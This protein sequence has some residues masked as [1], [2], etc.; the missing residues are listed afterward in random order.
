VV[1]RDE[2]VE[3]LKEA[4]LKVLQLAK[5]AIPD[6][7]VIDNGFAAAVAYFSCSGEA[8]GPQSVQRPAVDTIMAGK[9]IQDRRHGQGGDID[10]TFRW[11]HLPANNVSHGNFQLEIK[12]SYIR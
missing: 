11:F 2:V 9:L 1:G 4:E 7:R 3:L 12:L 5:V 10:R 6:S 8:K